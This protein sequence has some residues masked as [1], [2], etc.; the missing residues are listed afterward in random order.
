MAL[1]GFVH[2]PVEASQVPASWHASIAVQVTGVPGVHEPD[3]Q[4]SE[5]LQALSSPHD[6][7]LGLA[8]FVH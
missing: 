7:P 3:W 8:G 2:W 1:A 4:V 6:E 5:P